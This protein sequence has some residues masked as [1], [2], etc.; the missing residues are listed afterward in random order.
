MGSWDEATHSAHEFGGW[1]YTHIRDRRTVFFRDASSL[2]RATRKTVEW[3]ETGAALTHCVPAQ[4]RSL[5]IIPVLVAAAIST[6]S[7]WTPVWRV[8]LN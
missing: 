2:Q 1:R 8:V 4:A 6:V 5:R 3:T 7:S